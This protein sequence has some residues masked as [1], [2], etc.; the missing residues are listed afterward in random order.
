[1]L[2]CDACDWTAPCVVVQPALSVS[3]ACSLACHTTCGLACRTALPVL[4]YC[5]MPSRM[6]RAALS[7]RSVSMFMSM[8]VHVQRRHG[9]P[10]TRWSPP[11]SNPHNARAHARTRAR[12]RTRTRARAHA[13]THARTHPRMPARTRDCYGQLLLPSGLPPR[14]LRRSR[15]G[16]LPPGGPP[17]SAPR[18]SY[19]QGVPP[20]AASRSGAG[21]QPHGHGTGSS[22]DAK[23]EEAM[24]A[25]PA[26]AC[27]RPNPL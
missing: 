2:T 14:P 23:M 12:T 5:R 10:L 27:P 1:M 21:L 19:H 8:S 15:Q 22:G 11:G 7:G 4:L 18:V 24:R 13:R 6:P 3:V 17:P 9:A 20:I 25:A 26:P 16:A